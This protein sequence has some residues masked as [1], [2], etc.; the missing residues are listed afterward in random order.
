MFIDECSVC[1]EEIEMSCLWKKTNTARIR[2]Y[3]FRKEEQNHRNL[4]K[5]YF[6]I[7]IKPSWKVIVTLTTLLILIWKPMDSKNSIESGIRRYLL[8]KARVRFKEKR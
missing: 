3:L 5:V 2:T 6:C 4:L 7:F 8:H 1:I